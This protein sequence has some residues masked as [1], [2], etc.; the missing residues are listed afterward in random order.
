MGII[1]RSRSA[2]WP[3]VAEYV[4]NFSDGF[5][6]LAALNSPSLV[7][8]PKA[9]VTDF[10]SKVQPSGVLSGVAYTANDNASTKF[11]EMLALPLGAQVLSGELVIEQPYVGP[12]SATL[13]IGDPNSTGLYLAAQSLVAG[14][15]GGATTVSTITNAGADPTVVTLTAS[16]AGH[17]VVVGDIIQVSGCTGASAPYNGTFVVDSVSGA[18]II[19]NAPL[20]QTSLTTAG[21]PAAK[22]L[23]Q[24]RT[25]FTIPG[26]ESY[27][28]G[29][30]YTVQSGQ[31]G[32]LG[33]DI[34][35]TMVMSGGQAATAGRVRV[36]VT[37][38]IDGR[39]NE[40]ITT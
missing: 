4:F 35:G 10:G 18:A 26:Q 9:G 24:G 33:A 29:Q 28:G 5:V 12:T 11:L 6:P 3:L 21:A 23:H 34:R 27:A 25:A 37:Y 16:G 39:A 7:N 1:Q 31:E 36:R 20:I 13:A 40:V 15:L 22:Y 17:L 30:T 2:Q 19:Y 38:T 32:A 14:A 8:T